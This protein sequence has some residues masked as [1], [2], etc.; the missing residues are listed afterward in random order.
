MTLVE[1]PFT[2]QY[3]N[4]LIESY[5]K[6]CKLGSWLWLQLAVCWKQQIIN[7]QNLNVTARRTAP[8]NSYILTSPHQKQLLTMKP[9]SNSTY[10]KYAPTNHKNIRS[11]QSSRLKPHMPDNTI[12]IN[13]QKIFQA[14]TKCN[15][16]RPDTN[17]CN[18]YRLSGCHRF[19]L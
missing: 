8:I 11:V 19:C 12:D 16:F 13:I 1:S 2:Q 14:F 17:T 10:P 6:I 18:S 15:L 7:S 9:A 4:H 3:H 5:S